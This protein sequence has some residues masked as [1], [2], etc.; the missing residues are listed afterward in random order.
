MIDARHGLKEQEK[1]TGGQIFGAA[2]TAFDCDRGNVAA[3][4][5]CSWQSA[6]DA[7][8]A[9]SFV[10]EHTSRRRRHPMDYCQAGSLYV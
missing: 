3:R 4:F 6:A 7:E 5:D 1:E 8:A 10:L 9:R 2:Y